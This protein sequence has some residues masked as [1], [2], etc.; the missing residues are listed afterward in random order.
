[1]CV[2]RW[3]P[4]TAHHTQPSAAIHSGGGLPVWCPRPATQQT[5]KRKVNSTNSIRSVCVCIPLNW[6]SKRWKIRQNNWELLFF[7]RHLLRQNENV[8]F[9]LRRSFYYHV[10]FTRRPF[11]SQI[12]KLKRKKQKKHIYC[13]F[14]LN[15]SISKVAGEQSAFPQT[16]TQRELR[17]ATAENC[18]KCE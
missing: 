1:M 14:S 16:H 9:L 7:Y 15:S 5:T 17:A 10:L 11:S 4:H 8:L 3:K 13:L 2:C 6:Q 12:E 18:I